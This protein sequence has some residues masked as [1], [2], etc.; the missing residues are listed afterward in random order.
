MSRISPRLLASLFLGVS[1]LLVAPGLTRA[2]GVLINVET[3]EHVVLPRPI[4]IES[5]YYPHPHPRPMPIP[6]STYKIK[7]LEVDVKLA[8]QVA[9]VQVAQSFVNTGS[10]PMEV[11]FVFPLPYDGAVDQLTLLIDGKEFP[12]KLLPADEARHMYEEIVRK[13]RDPALLEWMGTGLFKTSVFPVPPGAE[14]KVTLR[15]SQLCRK[16]DGLTDF[17]FPLSTAKY[18]SHPVES[19]KFQVAIDSQTEI[20][21]VYSPTHAVEIKRP[22]DK[23]A[24]VS[25]KA[26]DKVPSSDFRLF[27]DVGQGH[28]GATV[29]SY[30][31]D[32]GEDG[33][34]LLLAS[35]E[36]KAAGDERPKKTVV[37]V[38]DRS[39][40][41][42]GEKIEQAKGA[43]KFVLN[44]LREGDLFNIIAFDSE[45]ESWKPELQKYND[46][47]RKAALGFIEGI[48]AGG[49]TNINGALEAA[50]GPL[51]DSGRP[52][53][54][55]FLTD[56]LPTV[57]EQNEAKIIENAKKYN[58]VNARIYT[59]GVGYDLNS[60]L[61]DKLA[62]EGFGQS[63][64]V[65]PNENIEDRVS[66]LY[67]RISAPVLSDLS[68]KW[69]VEGISSS[70]GKPVN[71]VYPKDVRALSAG[72]QLIIVGRYKKPGDAK[73]IVK[74]K[75]GDKEEKF[76]FPAKLV[77][78]SHDEGMAFIEKLWAVRRIGEILD[79]LDLKGK[80]DELVKE[81]VTLSR[82]HGVLTPYT[83]FMAD[84][85]SRVH[86][87]T[88]LYRE[89][90]DRLESLKEVEGQIGVEQRA[91]KAA[92]RSANAPTDGGFY[93]GNGPGGLGKS[94]AKAAGGG[95]AGGRGF[96]FSRD[97]SAPSAPLS[98][99]SGLAAPAI[100]VGEPTGFAASKA[101]AKPADDEG[102]KIAEN[103]RS[104]GRKVFYRRGD[105]WVDSTV[106][107]EQEKQPIK[108]ERY[109]KEY[110]DLID[111]Y[112]R[113]VAKYM[114]FD[115]PVVI[116][117]DGKAYSF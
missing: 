33:Y 49:S 111:K 6:E 56:G 13:N 15:Y 89:A 42:S 39:G 80:N 117:L 100:I 73:V 87:V 79:E 58:K 106:T 46:E 22:D 78:K 84:E 3:N 51:H 94:D 25:Y 47:T 52:T 99:A 61:L 67:K 85:N 64:F 68:I 21:N 36:I 12:A 102:A 109:S 92:L 23:H 26:E 76:D 9:K 110:F 69:D 8:E 97:T 105:R 104:I 103:V 28:V 29:L 70:D 62:R 48:Y 14:R 18:T 96:Y 44:N 11:C 10:R 19:I 20:K 83:S 108:I 45:V 86:E 55:L 37:F 71:R 57:G 31:H 53:I 101:G 112:G 107:A 1:A 66:A 38:V 50:F 32:V 41:M 54:V 43:A 60:R 27:Y 114:T 88:T 24:V 17:L 40:S 65:R 98:S 34:F 77:E 93:A 90:G 82:R 91:T 72:E 4:I 30:R 16:T 74:G 75:V 63:E 115:E 116:E 2:Q 59:F 81:L 7:E 35:P 113:D 5:P 95:Q